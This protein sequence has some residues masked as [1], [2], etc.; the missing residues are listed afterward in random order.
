MRLGPWQRC[1]KMEENAQT[2]AQMHANAPTHAQRNASAPS[3]TSTQTHAHETKRYDTI[4]YNTVQ[5]DTLRYDAI[6]YDAIRCDTTRCNTMR[7][8]ESPCDTIRYDMIRLVMD[9]CFLG[10]L[11]AGGHFFFGASRRGLKFKSYFGRFAP[12][13]FVLVFIESV[14]FFEMIILGARRTIGSAAL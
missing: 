7:Y 12:K 14:R 6:R 9:K 8:D 1:K 3:C 11:R 5:Y 13:R 10:A 2:H 4:R